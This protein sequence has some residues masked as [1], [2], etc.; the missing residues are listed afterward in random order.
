MPRKILVLSAS[1][2]AGHLR[3]AE[4]VEAAL[5]QVVP[6]AQVTNV[7][8][9]EMTNALFRRFYGKL[10]LDLVNKAPHVLGYFYDMLDQPSKS[11][12]Y[13]GD[14]FRLAVQKFNLRK[15]M[16]FLKSEPW[17]LVIN[18]HFLPAEIIASLRNSGEL[19]VPQAT[20]TTDFDTH[21]L[22]VNQPCDRYFTAT[23]EG[24]L[25]LQHWGVPAEHVFAT[26]I[27]V[28]PVFSAPKDRAA[29]L[30]KHGLDGSRPV[31]MQL[32]GGFGVGPIEKLFQAILQTEVPLQLVT[33][34]GRNEK[35][36]AELQKMPVPARHKVK[37]LGFTK[38]IDELM[39]AA[40]LIITKPGGLTTSETL[41]RGAV[42]VIVNP[43]PG[44]ESR[45][46]DYL[47]ESGAAIKVN[48]A[49]ILAHKL[50]RLLGDRERL[51]ALRANVQR[52]A[53][54]RAAFEVVEKSLEL[55]RR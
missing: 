46:S 39:Q 12:R 17:D 4:A 22:W 48:N 30:A 35:L 43:I 45:N 28:H 47:L 27:P 21:R 32:S 23:Q 40:D 42:M 50:T 54:P 49:A 52:I 11:G 13:R 51:A 3:A 5:R 9:L 1:V 38:E 24:A 55:I 33:I 25:Y 18:T 14:K 19:S 31:V 8:V 29:C 36:K 20:A 6:D 53:R 34:A 44:Q 37:V 41:A 2:G 15:F 26:G 10:Y 16:R 7:D